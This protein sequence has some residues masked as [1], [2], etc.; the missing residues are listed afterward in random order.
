MSENRTWLAQRVL[1]CD[2]F[3][4][5]ENDR[6][7]GKS[8]ESNNKVEKKKGLSV[9]I[10]TQPT[11]NVQSVQSSIIDKS[12]FRV[13]CDNEHIRSRS[14]I[15]KPVDRKRLRSKT[16]SAEKP[17]SSTL[18][19]EQEENVSNSD[20]RTLF[21]PRRS[22]SSITSRT[23]RKFPQRSCSE[24]R[25]PLSFAQHEKKTS[26]TPSQQVSQDVKQRTIASIQ[27][28]KNRMSKPQSTGTI[29][30][31]NTKKCS[32]THKKIKLESIKKPT[33]TTTDSLKPKNKHLLNEV[34]PT[35]PNKN[36]LHLQENNEDKNKSQNKSRSYVEKCSGNFIG[37][38]SPKKI[39]T[40][41][42][43]FEHEMTRIFTKVNE[44]KDVDI[45][46]RGTYQFTNEWHMEYVA[47]IERDRE[48]RAPKLSSR[49]LHENINVQQRKVIV[50]YLIRLGVRCHYP[51][52][53]IY[54]TVKLFNIAI[55]RILVELKNVQLLALTALWIVLKRE[56]I[57][58]KVPSVITLLKNAKD[59]Y[60]NQEKQ[61]LQYE[62][63]ILS[64][65]KF[66][67]RFADPYSLLLY[68]IIRVNQDSQYLINNT[69]IKTVYF[70]GSYL[71][72]VSMLDETLCNISECILAMAAAELALHFVCPN[73][74][75]VS[76]AWCKLWRR[77][78]LMEWE[79]RTIY[80]V[81]RRIIQYAA[82][83][84]STTKTNSHIVYNKYLSCSYCA[85]SKFLYKKVMSVFFMSEFSQD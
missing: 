22:F 5:K 72:D 47:E 3:V 17:S 11:S 38:S 1:R 48:E 20:L 8:N 41:H 51:S 77:K 54:Q 12:N 14:R 25:Q 50:E 49:F 6:S 75:Q 39:E 44:V 30:K 64:V 65:V 7:I 83:N 55:D 80:F 34:I 9:N 52:Y 73:T 29:P 19:K 18:R 74:S 26:V 46:L 42:E 59:M 61:L 78:H 60:I 76:Q 35:V 2:E 62:K 81:K 36:I 79:E 28:W 23:T 32:S 84:D 85:I 57:F 15:R 4:S 82:N 16:D 43:N 71:L 10:E 58:H 66:N 70:C 27:E 31:Q 56:L 63:K 45:T 69:D 67:T 24:S 21:A 33:S 37:T 40:C 53:I 68:Y 13:Y